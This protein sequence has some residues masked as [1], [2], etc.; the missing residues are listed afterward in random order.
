MEFQATSLDY[1]LLLFIR[2][3]GMTLSSPIFGR[4]NIPGNVKIVFSMALTYFFYTAVP[5]LQPLEYTSLAM[6]V[7]LCIKE[8]A[9]G[10]VMG[11]ILTLFFS[12]AFTAGQMIDMQLGF[13]MVNVFDVQSN[14]SVPVF[15]SMINFAM[16]LVFYLTNGHTRL[17]TMLGYTLVDIPVGTVVLLPALSMVLL[18]LFCN[19]F[20]LVAHMA[21]PII[22]SGLLLEVIMGLVIRTVPQLNVFSVGMPLKIIAGLFVFLTLIPVYVA[23]SNTVFDTMFAGIELAFSQMAGG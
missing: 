20:V 21:L 2:V 5:Q 4:Q 22:A 15:G 12:T 13:G 6:F 19:S 14:A 10:M 18:E 23:Y 3:S 16:L 7:L 9:I 8:L 11:Y 17:I 1:I